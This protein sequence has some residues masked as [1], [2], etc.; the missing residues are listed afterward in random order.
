LYR[1]KE[2]DK[3]NKWEEFKKTVTEDDKKLMMFVAKFISETKSQTIGDY[4]VKIEKKFNY[5][6]L[7]DFID[8]DQV[9]EKLEEIKRQNTELCKNNKE[10]IDLF[11]DN[12]DKKEKEDFD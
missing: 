3:E 5:K 2:W 12:F 9:K 7:N 10:A 1:W 8:V 11:L 4:G 6:S